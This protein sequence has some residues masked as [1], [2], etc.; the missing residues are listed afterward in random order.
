MRNELYKKIA[1]RYENI[2]IEEFKNQ[3]KSS[4]HF[5]HI[6][7]NLIGSMDG[8]ASVIDDSPEG[9]DSRKKFLLHLKMTST[10]LNL[11]RKCPDFREKEFTD[12]KGYFPELCDYL[13]SKEGKN[14]RE[15]MGFGGQSATYYVLL[16]K[17]KLGDV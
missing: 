2:Y 12:E 10:Y 1:K 17:Q 9:K 7:H 16:A 14:E 5:R 3:P 13:W 11:I 4:S 6:A 8:F 15:K